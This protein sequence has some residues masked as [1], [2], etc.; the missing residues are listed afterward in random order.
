M[1]KDFLQ[2]MVFMLYKNVNSSAILVAILVIA[3]TLVAAASFNHSYSALAVS[4][5]DGNSVS[6]SSSSATTTTNP[7][8]LSKND[9]NSLIDCINTA[10]NSRGLTHKVL[11]N[12][13]DTVK[14]ITPSTSTSGAVSTASTTT[15]SSPGSITPQGPIP[16]L[17]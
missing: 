15:P 17:P 2:C 9:L 5:T 3:L 13:L 10:N 1:L 11:T 14:G 16:Y 12:C 4:N 7:K 8:A 6:S